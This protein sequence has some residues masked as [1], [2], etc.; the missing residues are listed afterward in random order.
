VGRARPYIRG[1]PQEFEGIQLEPPGDRSVAAAVTGYL[2]GLEARFGP[3]AHG[4]QRRV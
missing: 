2:W 4:L 1:G 3:S